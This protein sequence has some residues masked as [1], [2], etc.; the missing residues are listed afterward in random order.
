M[1]TLRV[2]LSGCGR[3][4]AEVVQAV[5][6]HDYCDVVAL[7]DPDP[8][9][10]AALGDRTGIAARSTDFQALLATG[11]DFVVL[12]GPCGDRLAQVTEAAAQGAHCC[13]HAPIAPD[14]ATA[15]RMVELCEQAGVKLGVV[16]PAQAAPVMD[17]IRRMI[18]GDWLGAPVL[19]TAMVGEDAV[20][21]TPPGPDHWLRDPARA[22]SGALLQ[23]AAEAL[24]LV[25][26]LTERSPLRA[27]ALATSGFTRLPQDGAA[28]ALV[29]RGGIVCTIAASH[30]CD[31]WA[32]AV[33]GT[34][35]AVR[36]AA[37]RIWLRGRKAWNGEVLTYPTPHVDVLVPRL[38]GPEPAAARFELHGRFARWIDDY[39]DFPCP[40]D[41]AALDLQALDAARRAVEAGAGEDVGG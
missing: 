33:H 17:E 23:L 7:H 9:A 14:A 19:V 36:I 34:D 32:L 10:L 40:G 5:R 41:Q 26:W 20:L 3:R 11:V 39:D 22:G 4:G 1:N 15:A 12:T 24:H 29:L 16:V 27:T 30:L 6:T 8:A 18:A 25:V 28:A 31:G 35:G 21:R 2:G 38:D 13:V 37:D